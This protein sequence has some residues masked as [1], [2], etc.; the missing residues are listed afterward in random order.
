M[1]IAK[2]VAAGA[3]TGAVLLT[4]VGATSGVAFAGKPPA[5]GGTP[6]KAAANDAHA[7]KAASGCWQSGSHW[8]CVNRSGAPVVGYYGG[9]VGYMY[10]TTSWFNY[11]CEGGKSNNGPHPNR[12]EYTQADN[13][14]WGYMSDGD[15]ASETNPLPN[16]GAC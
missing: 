12:W 3:V 13:G 4:G 8:W 14:A 15:I 6:G 5:P 9:V 16:I 1:R 11:R 10:S 2:I 7:T